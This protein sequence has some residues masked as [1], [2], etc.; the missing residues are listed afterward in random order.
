MKIV[1]IQFHPG[2]KVYSYLLD[3]K[4]KDPPEKGS[5]LKRVAG[6][7]TY[8]AYYDFIYVVDVVDVDRLPDVVTSGLTINPE[9][10][11]METYTFKKETL[12]KLRKIRHSR[13]T[14]KTTEGQ[15]E[16]KKRFAE[17]VAANYTPLLTLQKL[18]WR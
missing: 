17:L 14:S 8:G 9:R 13:T 1:K 5:Y 16:Q 4:I 12:I 15:D 6:C 3:N 18:N 11:T 7:S 10:G 2:G